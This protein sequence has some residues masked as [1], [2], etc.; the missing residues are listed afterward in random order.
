MISKLYKVRK[1]EKFISEIEKNEIISFVDS[2]K[3][4]SDVENKHI[5]SIASKLNGKSYMFDISK[6]EK[7]KKLSTFQSSNNLVNIDFTRYFFK[8][9]RKNIY[10]FEDKQG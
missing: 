7:S 4:D 10:F 5:K 9:I 2:I 8:T 3:I 6:T 1:I